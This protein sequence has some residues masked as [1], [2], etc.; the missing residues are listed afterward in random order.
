MDGIEFGKKYRDTVTGFEGVATSKQTHQFGC[1]QV[2]LESAAMKD[3]KPVG[4]WFDEPR[5]VLVDDSQE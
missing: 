2:Y 4:C 5:L 1:P 3:G